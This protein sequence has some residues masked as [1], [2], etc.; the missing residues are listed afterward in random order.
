M[1]TTILLTTA[2]A[3]IGLSVSPGHANVAE[4]NNNNA[5]E[6][7]AQNTATVYVVNVKGKG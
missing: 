2:L 5:A 4:V 6:A 7:P 3:V 1:K